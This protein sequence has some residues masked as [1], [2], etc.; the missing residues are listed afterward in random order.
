EAHAHLA[1]CASC[2]ASFETLTAATRLA[3]QLPLV[4]PPPHV[5]GRVME[6]AEAHAREAIARQR[7]AAP[8]PTPWQALLDFVGRLATRPQVAMATVM[9]LIVAVGLW[10]LPRLRHEPAVAGG[11]VVN[12]EPEGEAAPSPGVE[13]AERL[14]LKVD[15]RAGRIRSKDAPVA[16]AAPAEPAMAAA[17]EPAPEE[18][19]PEEQ[20]L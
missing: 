1:T 6:L 11:V 8:R 10:S 18:G 9:V 14:D 12:P 15:M 3:A 2:R 13:P 16:A 5:A 17:P 4:E 19:R 7:V 20:K